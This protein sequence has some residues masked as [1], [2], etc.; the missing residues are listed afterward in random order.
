[1]SG[2]AAVLALVLALAS[3]G[4]HGGASAAGGSRLTVRWTGA[5]TAEISA[6]AEAE[7]CDS[8]RVLE[9]RAMAGDTGVG[10]ALYPA[11]SI[12]AGAYPVRRPGV[13][14]STRPPAA[15]LGLRWFSKTSVL[16]FQG[17][18]GE[19]ALE[20][21]ADGTLSGRFSA[22]ARALVGNGRLH[23]TGSFDGLR[24]TNASPACAGRA[25]PDTTRA[26]SGGGD[27][28]EADPKD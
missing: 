26:D 2:R 27:E 5:D 17:D 21:R 4:C 10:I 6:R 16:G 1:M 25:P 7:W 18:S 8:L 19:L 13:A 14:D 15:A 9:I 24:P 23:V 20:R 12:A 11:G 28:P 22:A 3:A